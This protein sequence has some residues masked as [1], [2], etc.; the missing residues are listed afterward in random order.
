M[1]PEREAI[2]DLIVQWEQARAQGRDPAPEVP[3]WDPGVDGSVSPETDSVPVA[4]V[5]VAKG[6][7]VRLRPIISW[8]S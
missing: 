5:P 6:S 1:E 2:L 7:R 4:G 8:R 3:W